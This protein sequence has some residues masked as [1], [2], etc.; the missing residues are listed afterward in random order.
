[1]HCFLIVA[2]LPAH[3]DANGTVFYDI[4][5]YQHGTGPIDTT[6]TVIGALVPLIIYIV[7]TANLISQYARFGNAN[8]AFVSFNATLSLQF[9]LVFL[10]YSIMSM[11]WLYGAFLADLQ[12]VTITVLSWV[13][14]SSNPIIYYVFNPTVR[15]AITTLLRLST[16]SDSREGGGGI[17][18]IGQHQ[19]L[20]TAAAAVA[21][22]SLTQH[23]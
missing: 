7:V 8:A 20:T 23:R 14:Y 15:K 6:L 3:L 9:F 17:G 12:G 13:C 22:T 2:V 16:N 18:R 21:A 10:F 1:M 19:Q 5:D 11:V 4:R